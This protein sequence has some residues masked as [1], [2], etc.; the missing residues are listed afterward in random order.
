[1]FWGIRFDEEN[2]RWIEKAISESDKIMLEY[3]M[4]FP[5]EDY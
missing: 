5:L 1:M 2:T 3:E 4:G